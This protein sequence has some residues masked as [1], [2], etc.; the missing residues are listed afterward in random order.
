MARDDFYFKVLV[1][2][3][4]FLRVRYG[5]EVVVGQCYVLIPCRRMNMRSVVVYFYDDYLSVVGF[6]FDY[7]DPL[8]LDRLVGVVDGGG[9]YD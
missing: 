8:L 1:A 7:D 6:D 5:D 9:G 4:E 2:V 3:G